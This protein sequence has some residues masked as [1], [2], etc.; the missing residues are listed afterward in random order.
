MKC[1]CGC[2]EDLPERSGRGR[3]NK[4]ISDAHRI[5]HF[6]YKPDVTKIQAPKGLVLKYP[7]SKWKL[8]PWI[9]AQFPEHTTYLEPY[10]GSGSVF[11]TK[12]PSKYEVINDLDEQVTNLF[13]VIRNKGT[14]L[15]QLIELTPWS[16]QE[17][18][19]AYELTGDPVEDARRFLVRCWMAH[20]VKTSDRTGWMNRGPKVDGSTTTRWNK[21]PD[22]IISCIDRLKNV[23]IECIPALDLLARFKNAQNCLL[24]V[25]PPYVLSTRSQRMYKHEMKDTEHI[26]LLEALNAHAGPVILSGYAHSLYDSFLTDWRR[27]TIEAIAEKGQARTEVLWMKNIPEEPK[28]KILSLFDEQAV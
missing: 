11:F 23:D 28:N 12:A 9:I 5:H 10:F 4:Y 14:K 20:G 3:P 6:R 15:A 22:R 16:R 13:R 18:Y 1:L 17:Y 25:D 19:E 21:L 24:Y 8:A 27:I 2:G 7:G 26:A